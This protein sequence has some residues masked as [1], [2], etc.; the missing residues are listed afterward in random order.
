MPI[1]L[2]LPLAA[3]CCFAAAW[4]TRGKTGRRAWL[5][6]GSAMAALWLLYLA[7]LMALELPE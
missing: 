2:L 3:L 6:L 1:L 7:M 5:A 4:L